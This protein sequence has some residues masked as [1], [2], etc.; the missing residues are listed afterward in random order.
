MSSPPTHVLEAFGTDGVAPVRLPGGADTSWRAGHLVLK[1]YDADPDELA[2]QAAT[3]PQ[4]QCDGFRLPS[5]RR[6]KDGSLLVDGWSA[7]DLAEGRH[8]KGRWEDI[9]AVGERFHRALR[10]IAR[11]AFLDQRANRWAVSDRVA[12]GEL[13]ADDFT[14][15]KYLA[16]LAAVLRP[17][18]GESQLIHGDLSGNVLFHEDLPPAIIDFSFYWRPPAYASAIVV[19]DA[20]VWASAD[21]LLVQ[22]LP[23]VRDAGQ[24]LARALI[25]RA[26]TD[27]LYA[28][29]RWCAD[30]IEDERWRSAVDLACCLA[31]RT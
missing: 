6:A 22:A 15:V 7:S 16:R 24:Y 27:W 21:N 12:W 10:G 14:D 20:L 17:V 4:V 28:G 19:A 8:E 3:F 13:P 5:P 11:P 2:W 26:V 18:P 31:V 9:I 30:P 1:P 23:D 29:E 25:F